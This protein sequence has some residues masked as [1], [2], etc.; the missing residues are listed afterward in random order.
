MIPRAFVAVVPTLLLA[1][2]SFAQTGAQ[3]G[4]AS[5]GVPVVG[6][7]NYI[8]AVSDLGRTLA[9]YHD[10]FGLDAQPRA[11][12]NPGVPALTNSPGVSLRLAVLRLPNAGFGFELTQFSGVE[13]HPGVPRHTDP[14]AALIALRVKDLAPVLAAIKKDKVPIITTSGGPVLIPSANGKIRGM[15][16]RDPDGYVIEVVESKPPAGVTSPGNV[17][18]ASMGLTVAD[19]ENTIQFWHGLLGFDLKGKMEFSSDPAI[20]DLTG[21]RGAKNRELVANVPGTKALM[22]FYEY[23]GIPRTPFHRRVPDPGAPAVALR[24]Q[25]L[26]GLLQ[27]MRAAG[28]RV[29]SLH[30]QVVQFTPTIRNIFVEDPNGLNIELFESKQ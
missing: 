18:E 11:F 12:P 21:A 7:L 24:V 2:A 17:F 13:R 16:I 8:H 1:T 27:R 26:D 23:Q 20:L 6:I 10:V 22:A 5:S 28:V 19:M 29:T 9:F 14:G 3:T 15:L 30:G 25:D 4:S